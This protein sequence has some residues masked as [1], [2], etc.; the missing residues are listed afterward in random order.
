MTFE[1]G[2]SSFQGQ[3]NKHS[4]THSAQ[5]MGDFTFTQDECLLEES[6]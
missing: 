6:P 3:Y 1:K 2:T 5:G 4:Q